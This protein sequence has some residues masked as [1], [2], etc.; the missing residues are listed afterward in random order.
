[1]YSRIFLTP[2]SAKRTSQTSVLNKYLPPPPS[3]ERTKR[4]HAYHV[5]LHAAGRTLGAQASS[6]NQQVLTLSDPNGDA[7]AIVSGASQAEAHLKELNQP[8]H[9]QLDKATVAEQDR[10]YTGPMD[11]DEAAIKLAEQIN[12]T[13]WDSPGDVEC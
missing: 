3:P 2:G 7:R 4:Q 5:C 6:T 10:F 11:V 9:V 12:Q 8:Q 13:Y 1:M